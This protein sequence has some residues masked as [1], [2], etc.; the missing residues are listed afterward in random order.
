MTIQKC[1]EPRNF[2]EFC[3]RKKEDDDWNCDIDIG[4]VAVDDEAASAREENGG[5]PRQDGE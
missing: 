2:T 1:P 5:E 4:G 3:G